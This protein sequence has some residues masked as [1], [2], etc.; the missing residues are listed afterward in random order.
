MELP[1]GFLDDF[2]TKNKIMFFFWEF[3]GVANANA[4]RG[5][6]PVSTSQAVFEPSVMTGATRSLYN[7]DKIIKSKGSGMRSFSFYHFYFSGKTIGIS[8]E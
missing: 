3:E 4:R 6:R 1:F 8:L 5:S 7:H 2:H